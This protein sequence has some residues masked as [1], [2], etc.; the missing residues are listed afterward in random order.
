MKPNQVLEAN[1]RMFCKDRGLKLVDLA[2]RAGT[3]H[4]TFYS[5]FSG[6]KSPTLD[7]LEPVA[8]ALGVAVVDLLTPQ[9]ETVAPKH[10]QRRRPA[11]QRSAK[12]TQGDRARG[13]GCSPE[14][15]DEQRNHAI[16]TRLGAASCAET[17]DPMPAAAS[18]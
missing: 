9:D 16:V 7:S 11:R 6:A 17:E 15:G 3:G 4:S 14:T 8:H 18:R 1:V 12:R 2:S 13:N 10:K 5:W